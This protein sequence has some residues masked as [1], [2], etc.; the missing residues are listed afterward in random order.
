MVHGPYR[1]AVTSL[2]EGTKAS[3]RDP[4]AMIIYAV[5]ALLGAGRLVAVGVLGEPIG[6][7]ATVAILFV[8]FGLLG[9][10]RDGFR[11]RGR[12]SDRV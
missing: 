12:R 6:A 8:L 3:A 11:D 7:E 10:L 9:V 5:L 1:T 4:E 2:D